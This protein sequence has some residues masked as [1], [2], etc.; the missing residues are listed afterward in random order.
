MGSSLMPR[1]AVVKK[2]TVTAAKALPSA[3][4]SRDKSASAEQLPAEG[5]VLMGEELRPT[6]PPRQ[7]KTVR[8][9][10]EVEVKRLTE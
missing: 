8:I 9:D 5:E 10:D 6:R 3:M 7:Q 2:Q 1:K 4:A